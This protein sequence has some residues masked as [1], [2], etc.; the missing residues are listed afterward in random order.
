[1][2]DSAFCDLFWNHQVLKGF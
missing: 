2:I 1:M